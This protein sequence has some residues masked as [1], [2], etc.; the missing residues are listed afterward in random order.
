MG[1]EVIDVGRIENVHWIEG[2]LILR[3]NIRIS[4]RD[5]FDFGL[6]KAE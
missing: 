6:R 4:A 1:L 3:I 5:A 2:M